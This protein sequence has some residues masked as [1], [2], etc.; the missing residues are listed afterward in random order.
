MQILYT[1]QPVENIILD[2]AWDTVFNGGCFRFATPQQHSLSNSH[3][4]H[5]TPRY[6]Q[7]LR[8]TFYTR[9]CQ[10]ERTLEPSSTGAAFFNTPI[11]HLV[12]LECVEHRH[13]PDDLWARV[14][15]L[16]RNKR[17][18]PLILWYQKK[19]WLNSVK[20]QT[21]HQVYRRGSVILKQLGTAVSGKCYLHRG[22]V[23]K[24]LHKVSIKYPKVID[25]VLDFYFW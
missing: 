20:S 3:L 13:L 12:V 11:S 1:V 5:T 9:V 24:G 16:K 6:K 22:T 15:F 21:A 2:A 7:K 8:M 19:L 4:A 17:S 10:Y 14:H 18:I 23:C 25:I